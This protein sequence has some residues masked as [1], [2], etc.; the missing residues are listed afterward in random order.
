MEGPRRLLNREAVYALL[1][2]SAGRFE[3]TAFEVLADDEVQ[4]ST[5]S[6]LLEGARRADEARDVEPCLEAIDRLL[7]QA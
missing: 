4:A 7:E 3:F 1:R 5:T 2:C 6:L